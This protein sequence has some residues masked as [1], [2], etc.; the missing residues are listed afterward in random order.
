MN[1][2]YLVSTLKT[3]GPTNQLFELISNIDLKKNKV[4]I[5][6]ISE[7]PASRSSHCFFVSLGVDVVSANA[8]H[9]LGLFSA[10][11]KA[12]EFKDSF[13]PDVVHSSG[14]RSDLISLFMSKSSSAYISTIHC[15]LV[16]DYRESYG[17]VMGALFAFLHHVALYKTNVVACSGAVKS[18]LIKRGVSSHAIANGVDISKYSDRQTEK[19]K[20]IRKIYAQDDGQMIFIYTGPLIKRKRVDKVIASFAMLPENK[21]NVL[22]IAG[23]GP[24]GPVLKK[25]APENIVFLG[26]VDG[27]EHYLKSA[28]VY[29]S[30]SMAE[31]LPYSVLEAMSTGLICAVSNIESHAEISVD[32]ENVLLDYSITESYV[33]GL[34]EAVR[35]A[36]AGKGSRN[37]S[38]IIRKYSS[39]KMADEYLDFYRFWRH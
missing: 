19:A 21:K 23:E 8:S 34:R 1:I 15:D 3:T 32:S 6:K 17:V 35:R 29:L 31:G 9:G 22:L 4:A 39:S 20:N 7:E 18:S 16:K 25:N 37:R 27:V 28:D 12:L 30:A 10:M 2:L 33:E 14:I 24:L 38:L 36:V 26:Q 5:F 11:K 13:N